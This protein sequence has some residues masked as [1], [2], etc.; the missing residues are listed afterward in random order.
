MPEGTYSKAGKLVNHALNLNSNVRKKV[1]SFV[2][3]YS[4]KQKEAETA[5]RSAVLTIDQRTERYKGAKETS[6][7]NIWYRGIRS[8]TEKLNK[9]E[10][11]FA[12]ALARRESYEEVS[13]GAAKLDERLQA[14]KML[15]SAKKMAA[16]RN[17]NYVRETAELAR[18]LGSVLSKDL[19]LR[20]MG[21]NYAQI[22]KGI[23]GILA[24]A[25]GAQKPVAAYAAGQTEAAHAHKKPVIVKEEG[26]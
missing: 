7:A 8:G 10:T 14:C 24:T 16:E 21:G 15:L 17:Q 12:D 20:A 1:E 23:E 9:A 26:I 2:E 22:A 13:A 18:T 25:P 6:M 5:I 11:Q 19:N 4:A 3:S